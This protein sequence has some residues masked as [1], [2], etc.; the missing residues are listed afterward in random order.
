[1]DRKDIDLCEIAVSALRAISRN[2][3]NKRHKQLWQLAI[4]RIDQTRADVEADEE[5]ERARPPILN[6]AMAAQKAERDNLALREATRIDPSLANER[7]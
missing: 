1:M 3:T 5:I 7:Y 6:V 4:R 2:V